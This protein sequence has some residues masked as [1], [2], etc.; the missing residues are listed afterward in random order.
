MLFKNSI[1]T[2]LYIGILNICFSLICSYSKSDS[3]EKEN[4]S[5]TTYPKKLSFNEKFYEDKDGLIIV[6]DLNLDSFLKEFPFNLIFSF[7]HPCKICTQIIPEIQKTINPLRNLNTP[8]FVGKLNLTESHKSQV[9]LKIISKFHLSYFSEG[10][11]IQY[12]GGR[13][14]EDIVQWVRE[15]FDPLIG[16]IKSIEEIEELRKYS[17]NLVV[18]FGENEEK[19]NQF[20]LSARPK[21]T[22]LFVKCSLPICLEKYNMNTGDIR[23]F[24]KFDSRLYIIKSGEYDLN[25]LRKSIEE[26]LR[27]RV[28]KLE[29]DVFEYIFLEG[30][31]AL[32]I[33]SARSEQKKYVDMLEEIYEFAK[34]N[35]L[36]L[37]NC[38]L[39]RKLELKMKSITG[40]KNSELPLVVIHQTRKNEL[41]TF[42]M[43]KNKSIT[44]DNIKGFIRDFTNKNLIQYIKSQ[45]VPRFQKSFIK[46]IVGSTLENYVQD[47][48]TDFIVFFY[49]P[50][51]ANSK[52][53]M[54]LFTEVAEKLKNNNDIKF[55]T[56][57][58]F[59]ND[60]F[61]FTQTGYPRI[62][63]W[64][65]DK[66]TNPIV[67]EALFD[68]KDIFKF[69][70]ENI[71]NKFN[72]NEFIT[73]DDS[74]NYELD[75]ENKDNNPDSDSDSDKNEEN[76]NW[77]KEEI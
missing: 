62:A 11:P 71:Y 5:D 25:N 13:T 43:D 70:N 22:V 69:V 75:P 44:I 36:K 60:Q 20:F 24:R 41:K 12:D 14:G 49:A 9:R 72:I 56:F 26:I 73:K 40:F 53:V 33:Y 39:S 38:D 8:V 2:L 32:F 16:D 47:S 6:N 65:S 54:P 76:E 37:V 45:D 51:D 35:E 23:I 19:Y 31:S 3:T 57:D 30:N 66:K 61:L 63:I 7:L 64:P 17:E 29:R 59:N 67:S 58:A 42:V 18:F 52:T 1:I 55:G 46:E 77:K 28:M 4:N 74:E 50:W 21:D 15:K 10:I 27:G 68:V 48:S 34:E